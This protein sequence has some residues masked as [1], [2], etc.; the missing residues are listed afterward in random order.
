MIHVEKPAD[1]TGFVGRAL[2]RERAGSPKKRI[3]AF[4][5]QPCEDSGINVHGEAASVLQNHLNSSSWQNFEFVPFYLATFDSFKDRM[6]DCVDP[7]RNVAV[8]YI[9]GHSGKGGHLCF[10]KNILGKGMEMIPPG[11]VARA[12]G[13]GCRR[14]S[15]R[16]IW[17][18]SLKNSVAV[19]VDAGVR[20]SLNVGGEAEGVTGVLHGETDSGAGTVE[21]VVLNSCCTRLLGIQL[22]KEGVPHVVCW[23]SQVEDR[24]AAKFAERFFKR[25]A[26][27][28]RDYKTAFDE[29]Q[30]EVSRLDNSAARNLSFLSE[31]KV[32]EVDDVEDDEE[33]DHLSYLPK[34]SG[35]HM[36]VELQ[37]EE[38]HAYAGQGFRMANNPKG[39]SEIQ[40]LKALR[41]N[42]SDIE[43]GIAWYEKNEDCD[44]RILRAYGLKESK[45]PAGVAGKKLLMITEEKLKRIFSVSNYHDLWKENGAVENQMEKVD[46]QSHRCQ[47]S[48]SS[49][50]GPA[51][52]SG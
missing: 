26:T 22:R 50:V 48:L 41:F 5:A 17:G 34:Y 10:V 44:P 21:C 1:E 38:T 33:N 40:G 19:S 6:L 51:Q 29:G 52:T 45:F 27:N 9:A 13:R 49:F 18:P 36:D 20:E 42:V 46:V 16:H 11:L 28:P 12:I 43:K 7:E 15:T 30:E 23:R 35:E 3:Y 2:M 24:I 8:L 31:V 32:N 4:L 37:D 39:L 47:T 25:L 14:S